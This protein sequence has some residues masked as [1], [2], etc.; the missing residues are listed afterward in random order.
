MFLG[1]VRWVT[2]V[3]QIQ[4]FGVK[5]NALLVP[6]VGGVPVFQQWCCMPVESSMHACLGPGQVEQHAVLLEPGSSSQDSHTSLR[7]NNTSQ[8]DT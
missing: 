3:E 2:T 8:P 4:R 1:D 5:S 6:D 7:T